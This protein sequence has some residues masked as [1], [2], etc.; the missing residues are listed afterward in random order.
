MGF[1]TCIADAI[2]LQ[3]TIPNSE[4]YY[5]LYFPLTDKKTWHK[6]WRK[7]YVFIHFWV[8]A[9]DIIYDSG[10]EQFGESSLCITEK[11]DPRYV[12]VGKYLNGQRIPLVDEPAIIWASNFNNQTTVVWKDEA[13]HFRKLREWKMADI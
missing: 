8:E 6:D 11:S 5:G 1:A 7:G 10:A 12:K 4:I 13:T 9:K 2:A 3:K